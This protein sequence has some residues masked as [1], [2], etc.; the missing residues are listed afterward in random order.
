M[1]KQQIWN[2][3]LCRGFELQPMDSKMALPELV[4]AVSKAVSEHLATSA[5]V[6]EFLSRLPR[7]LGTIRPDSLTE[8]LVKY[9]ADRPSKIDKSDPAVNLRFMEQIV[10]PVFVFE[11]ETLLGAMVG[12]ANISS[13][14]FLL[15]QSGAT[16]TKYIDQ[17][18]AEWFARM[19]VP[20]QSLS[21][22]ER[23]RY[24]EAVGKQLGEP[25]FDYSETIN[26]LKLLKAIGNYSKAKS[27]PVHLMCDNTL[28]F[29][30]L[31]HGILVNTY[32]RTS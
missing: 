31:M 3:V 20:F 5:D 4:S 7:G 28:G 6:R 17:L 19:V 16:L 1:M 18:W 10:Q 30:A 24:V 13:S 9:V 32:L 14:D 11:H 25:E 27:V 23:N 21:E 26:A 12:N 2:D 15:F 29:I 22:E 8:E